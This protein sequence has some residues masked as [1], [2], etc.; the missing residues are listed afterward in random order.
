MR[1]NDIL[2]IKKSTFICGMATMGL[3]HSLY[4]DVIGQTEYIRQCT[5]HWV[6]G[7]ISIPIAIGGLVFIWLCMYYLNIEYKT[8][9]EKSNYYPITNLTKVKWNKRKMHYDSD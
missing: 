8:L 7:S 9:Y 6:P 4:Q 1:W 2:N 5:E 3:L